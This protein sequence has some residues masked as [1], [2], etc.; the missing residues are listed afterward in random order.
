MHLV[1]YVYKQIWL[2]ASLCHIFVILYIFAICSGAKTSVCSIHRCYTYLHRSRVWMDGPETACMCDSQRKQK[3]EA[4]AD[5][6]S[7]YA[8]LI[9]G[10]IPDWFI[11]IYM[12]YV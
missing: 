1:K 9:S 7:K 12:L 2:Y 4:A 6:M 8:Y 10:V 11:L 3:N 5:P